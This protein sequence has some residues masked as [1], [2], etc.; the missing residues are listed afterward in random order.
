MRQ[1]RRASRAALLSGVIG[2]DDVTLGT[3]GMANF[4]NKNVG[5]GKTVTVTGLS[6]GG[7]AAGN[8]QLSS[9][10]AITTANI[11]AANTASAVTSSANPTLPGTGV[12][13]SSTVSV[14]APGD[15]MP[16][17]SVTFKDGTGLLG[18]GTLDGSGV[19]S[20][21][22]SALAHG[23]HII[24]AEYAGDGNFVGSTNSLSPDQLVNTSPVACNT[25]MSGM[26]N[27]SLYLPA[28]SL[29]GK[30]TDADGDTMNITAVTANSAQGGTASLIG[31]TITYTPPTNYTGADS[32]T[33]TVSDSFGATGIG[34]VDVSV[35]ALSVPPVILELA[36]QPDGN[37]EVRASGVP[38]ETYLIQAG[39]KLTDWETI[40]TNAADSNGSIVFLDQNATNYTSRFYRLAAP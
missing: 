20:F 39:T 23:N 6:L 11:T 32:F 34:T 3:S 35:E 18:T 17:G 31:G 21:S 27:Q 8:Y 4:A 19:A 2:S 15:G 28:A 16:T 38:G 25:N 9:T 1:R 40:G 29:V 36:H 33:Y 7:T 10:T 30:C 22:T 26:K 37:M 24:T 14:A 12:T 13:F 5:T